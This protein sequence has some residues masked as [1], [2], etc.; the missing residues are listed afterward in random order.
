MIFLCPH[1]TIQDSWLGFLQLP[2]KFFWPHAELGTERQVSA[3]NGF[4]H[5]SSW[6]TESL[7]AKT[8]RFEGQKQGKMMGQEVA[9]LA[10]AV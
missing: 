8:A 4:E 3:E 5:T 7:G 9:V 10:P 2:S 1:L 6:W